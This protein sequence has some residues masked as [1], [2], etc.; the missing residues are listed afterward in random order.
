MGTDGAKL[1]DD[2]AVE[3]NAPPLPEGVTAHVV[4]GKVLYVEAEPV[5]EVGEAPSKS[6]DR[7]TWVDYCVRLGAD[8]H[9]LDNDTEHFI[10]ATPG[11]VKIEEHP[12]LTV[13][14]LKE[15]AKSLGG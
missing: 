3:L 12:A 1:G 4:E 6:A 7:E 10:D 5:E 11:Q 2:F 8:R 15:L 13:A 14:D 9:F